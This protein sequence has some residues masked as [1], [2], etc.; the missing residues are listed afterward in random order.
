MTYPFE[1]GGWMRICRHRAREREF[2]EDPCHANAHIHLRRISR[3]FLVEVATPTL[4]ATQRVKRLF[5]E[6]GSYT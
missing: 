4:E 3:D 1:D 6:R 5:V 2:K